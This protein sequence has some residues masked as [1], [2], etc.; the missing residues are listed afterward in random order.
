MSGKSIPWPAAAEVPL[1]DG[2][3]GGRQLTVLLSIQSAK[4]LKK[5]MVRVD[6]SKFSL[7]PS[8]YERVGESCHVT[9]GSVCDYVY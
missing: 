6:F 1:G 2:D 9:D 8:N 3:W 5:K 7:T 4:P